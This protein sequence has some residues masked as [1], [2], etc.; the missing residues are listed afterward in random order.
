MSEEVVL[1]FKSQTLCSHSERNPE[2]SEDRTFISIPPKQA[3]KSRCFMERNKK[4]AL[5]GLAAGIFCGFILCLWSK[6]LLSC[7]GNNCCLKRRLRAEIQQELSMSTP[8]NV[9]VTENIE[10]SQRK[11]VSKTL[12]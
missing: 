8:T 5:S 2:I 6:P 3:R 7:T 10:K 11:R 1:R 12:R 4:Y 9:V